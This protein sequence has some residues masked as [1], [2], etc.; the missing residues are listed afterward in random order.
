MRQLMIIALA[1]TF[2]LIANANRDVTS[3]AV[4]VDCQYLITPAQQSFAASGGSGGFSVLAASICSWTVTSDTPWITIT[5]GASGSGLG[6]VNY[7]VAA[8]TTVNPRSGTITVAG[9]TYTI[10]QAGPSNGGCA[11]TPI[12]IGQ[13]VNGA[14]TTSDCRSPLRIKDGARP[15]A[16]RYSFNATSGQ[17]VIISLS[18]G[19]FDTYLYLLNPDGTTLTQN[20]D[21]GTGGSRIP[22]G[23][24]F[25]T[26]PSSGTF[27]IEVTA[28]SA[29]E[30]GAYTLSLTAPVGGC[31]YALNPTNQ[32]F[33]AGGGAGIVNVTTQANCAWTAA[34]N[35]SWITITSGGPGGGS[36]AVNYSV[37]ANNSP[38]SRA[39][40]L[41]VAGLTF[42][43]NQAGAGAN[44]PV[45]SGVNPPSGA[46]SANVTI[47]GVNFTGV[48]AVKFSNNAVAQFT[49]NSDSQ[50]TAVVP[51]GA[52]NGPITISKPNCSET[53]TSNFT[54]FG[55]IA[56]VSAANYLGQ[57]LASESIV[58]AFGTNLATSIQV[59]GTT[60]LPVTLAGTTVKVRDGA[61]VERFSPLFF[62]SPTQ[63][64]YQIPAGTASGAATITIT[65]GSGAISIG[66]AQIA[67]LVPGLFTANASGQGIVSAIVIRVRQDGSQTVEPV[68]QFDQAQNSF[69]ALPIDLG[70]PTDQV[71]LVMFGTGMR[72]VTSLAGAKLTIG[73]TNTE[74]LYV[75]A[76]GGFV[77]L[78]QANAL[79]PRSLI[80]RSE[81]DVLLTLDGKTANTVRISVK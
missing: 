26:L 28:F 23:S 45:V 24:G 27:I 4:A 21:S 67:N 54:P 33:T 15:F 43:I 63:V 36:G 34:S 74:L 18:S 20:D 39:G 72:N 52:V 32:S 64:N 61:N 68:A 75:G 56:N 55:A 29:Q 69:V 17:P 30:L 14:L 65:S 50:I 25:L 5:A 44:C 35:N 11:V 57:A 2:V 22:V 60:P 59:A 3:G 70:P 46:V 47:T 16:D 31:S 78:D 48:N 81:M 73:G 77:G 13:T 79:L 1:T 62:V 41:T 12:S 42:T 71:Y 19:N 66:I 7:T 8:N 40:S 80:G 38:N 76:Q 6:R 53:Q 10:T 37:A 51:N 9:Q 49:V 58:A